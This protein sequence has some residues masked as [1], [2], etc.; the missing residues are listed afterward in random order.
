MCSKYSFGWNG[1]VY[2]PIERQQRDY[3]QLVAR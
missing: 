1:V 2:H 3:T